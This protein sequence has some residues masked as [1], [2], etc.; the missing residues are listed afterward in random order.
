MAN[1]ISNEEVKK[2]TG[3]IWSDW[4]ALLNKAGAKKM[5]HK[6]I[7]QLLYNKYGL[8]RWWSQMVTVIYE[9]DIK[10]R[11]KNSKPEGFQISKSKT[12]S[13]SASKVFS[14]IQYAAL[15][16]SW[17]KDPDF[18][19]TK[20][21][22]NKS[23]RGKWIDGKTKVEFQFYPMEKAKTQLVVQHSKI[24]SSKEAEKLKKY[25]ERNLSFLK[26]YL[27]KI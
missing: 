20:S 8:S 13:Y 6:D 17:L 26:K 14:V 1:K 12:L 22:K 11:K 16:K 23:I 27:E 25:W 15:R 21:M 10:G 24:S 4:F 3:K 7:A 18:S 5:E 9:Q 19:I 2:S